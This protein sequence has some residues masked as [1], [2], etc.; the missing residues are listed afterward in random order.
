MIKNAQPLKELEDT[1][2]KREG[3]LPFGYSLRIFESLWDEGIKLGVLP[4]RN[5]LE[6]IEVDIKIAKALN[7]CSGKSL[8]E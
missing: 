8:P 6:G 7:S 1:I 2:M 4:P 3:R 5:P